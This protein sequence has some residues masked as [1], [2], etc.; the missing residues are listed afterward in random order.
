MAESS[1]SNPT[2]TS[3]SDEHTDVERDATDGSA[4][5]LIQRKLEVPNMKNVNKN[6]SGAH[7]SQSHEPQISREI[8]FQKT[9]LEIA[10]EQEQS[11]NRTASEPKTLEPQILKETRPQKVDDGDLRHM[12]RD[13]SV[14]QNPQTRGKS[15]VSNENSPNEF[16][17]SPRQVSQDESSA[18]ELQT[19]R[20]KNQNENEN[21][22]EPTPRFDARHLSKNES[23]APGTQRLSS[24]NDVENGFDGV[25]HSTQMN[26]NPSQD[27]SSVMHQPGLQSLAGKRQ[28]ESIAPGVQALGHPMAQVEKRET[29]ENYTG[30]ETNDAQ[31]ETGMQALGREDIFGILILLEF[32]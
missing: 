7:P 32:Y 11:N 3:P 16:S 6:E 5:E 18:P 30:G 10:R 4:K 21:S 19:H 8:P 2:P 29:E 15:S 12:S 22:G 17:S 26:R 28:R 24:R 31:E 13:E 9:A 20:Q 1:K 23:G 14:K 25:Q 27:D